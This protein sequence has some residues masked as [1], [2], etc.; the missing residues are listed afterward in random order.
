MLFY[1]ACYI[2]SQRQ[3]A[4]VERWMHQNEL[5]LS[6]LMI[7]HRLVGNFIDF[8]VKKI[9]IISQQTEPEKTIF[10]TPIARNNSN[11]SLKSTSREQCENGLA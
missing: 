2:L 4:F 11:A 10:E 5:Q 3:F 1:N 8:S 6:Y 9:Y 7:R